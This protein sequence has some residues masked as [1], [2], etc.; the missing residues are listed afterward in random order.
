MLTSIGCILKYTFY[1][2]RENWVSAAMYLAYTGVSAFKESYKG[3]DIEFGAYF[4]KDYVRLKP[5][6]GAGLLFARGEVDPLYVLSKNSGWQ[7]TVHF[8]LG[9][10]FELPI[11][12]TAQLDLMNLSPAGS[13]L[14][15]KRF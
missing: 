8:F 3:S 9:L 4:S 6:L 7:S 2:E 1:T 5:F 13:I 11:N 14:L 10:E 15:A 12:F